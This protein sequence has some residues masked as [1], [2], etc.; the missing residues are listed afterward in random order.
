MVD[1]GVNVNVW[2]GLDWIL[3]YDV[4]FYGYVSCVLV[5]I[6]VGVDFSVEMDDFMIVLDMVEI[7]W[8]FLVI[9][10]VMIVMNI[11]DGDKN[12]LCYC[13]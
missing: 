6:N 7:D 3:F 10:W 5:L 13:E 9:G 11:S 2:N 1:F 12:K 4:V 8:M